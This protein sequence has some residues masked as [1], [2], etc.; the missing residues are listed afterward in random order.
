M[1]YELAVST[2]AGAAGFATSMQLRKPNDHSMNTLVGI[3]TALATAL[4]LTI[5]DSYSNLLAY[6]VGG[7]VLGSGFAIVGGADPTKPAHFKFILISSVVFALQASWMAGKETFENFS[8]NFMGYFLSLRTI[9]VL[10]L[11][12]AAAGGAI[13]AAIY[14]FKK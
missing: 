9:T 7:A 14:Y 11:M 3:I 6:M 1:S 2:A 4:F 12:T 8:F 5:R 10:T 13:G